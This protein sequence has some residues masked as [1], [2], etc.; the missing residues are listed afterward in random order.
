M[1]APRLFFSEEV[2]PRMPEALKARLVAQHPSVRLGAEE[3]FQPLE[4]LP[5]TML[6][7][8]TGTG[9]STSLKALDALRQSGAVT[10]AD[11]IPSRR[12][13]ADWVLIPTAQVVGGEKV[14]PIIER[15]E[16]FRLTRRFAEEV[17]A[18][19]SAA[20]YS[21]LYYQGQ[22]PL[23]SEALRGPRE[24]A[25]ALTHYPNWRMV[26][27]WV[28]PVIRLQRLSQR[29]DELDQVAVGTAPI[30]LEFLPPEQQA[31]VEVLL[32]KGTI[33][34]ESIVTARTE[35]QSYGSRPYDRHNETAHYRCIVIN[36]MQPD[37][38]ARQIMQSL[39][40]PL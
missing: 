38:V 31:A 35:A 21:W 15:T 6:V 16:R 14:E 7:G 25:Y 34:L 26:E 9:K 10:Y 27:L 1:I 2:W 28:D 30:D 37:A 18:G 39:Q 20:V 33:S 5:V 23:L 19:G 29:R 4:T 24:I 8:L 12:E 3:G 36:D 40:E 13:L 17:D 22:G 32:A 11:D